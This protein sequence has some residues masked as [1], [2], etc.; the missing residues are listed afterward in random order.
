MCKQCSLKWPEIEKEATLRKYLNYDFGCMTVYKSNLPKHILYD[1]HAFLRKLLNLDTAIAG[2]SA[3]LSEENLP[4]P[5]TK[6]VHYVDSM[7]LESNKTIYSILMN[8][9]LT[10]A[11]EEM[12]FLKFKPLFELQMRNG[13]KFSTGMQ[14]LNRFMCAELITI[15]ASV[16]REMVKELV[17]SDA[18]HFIC[19]AGDRT[20][21]RKTREE[22]ELVFAKFPGTG[23]KRACTNYMSSRMLPNARF[24]LVRLTDATFKVMKDALISYTPSEEVAKA[25]RVIVCADGASVNFGVHNGSL[26]Q[27]KEWSGNEPLLMHCLSHRLELAIKVAFELDSSFKEF[28]IWVEWFVPAF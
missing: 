25:M 24:S 27:L 19:L 12:S 15:L 10:I 8:T 26:T 20:E 14:K 6:K 9:A 16:V 11:L 1:M 3:A 21:A 28:K 2:P 5:W 22:K 4:T 18:T 23:R 17:C 13:V 7:I